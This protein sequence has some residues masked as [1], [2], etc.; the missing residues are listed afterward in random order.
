MKEDA[1]HRL[2]PDMDK[3]KYLK[4]KNGY[5][6]SNQRMSFSLEIYKCSHSNCKSDSEISNMLNHLM[7]N[8]FI[9]SDDVEIG[10]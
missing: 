1:S 9:L 8:V 2:C 7:F 10:N 4:A 6:N 5:T 3:M